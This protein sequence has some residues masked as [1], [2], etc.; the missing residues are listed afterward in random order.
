MLS[1][2]GKFR[3]PP[4][5]LAPSA[6]LLFQALGQTWRDM[7]GANEE[8]CMS[9]TFAVRSTD[10]RC[11]KKASATKNCGSQSKYLWE[12]LT[13]KYSTAIKLAP[14]VSGLFRHRLRFRCE[15]TF[16]CLSPAPAISA[17][18]SRSC[19]WAS[20]QGY[21]TYSKLH[22]VASKLATKIKFPCLSSNRCLAF[23]E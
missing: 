10:H 8:V 14:A 4:G 3:L 12:I 7:R 6:A 16:C 11:S 5:P 15:R 13:Q 18:K 22:P 9:D 2:G 20:P 23:N 1:P 17:H 19:S 21:A